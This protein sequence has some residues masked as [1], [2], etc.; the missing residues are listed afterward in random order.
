[1]IEL[2]VLGGLRLRDSADGHEI[3]SV[4]ARS[5]PPGVLLYLALSPADA[6]RGRDELLELLWP[7]SSAEKARNSLSQALHILRRGL[8]P[9]VIGTTEGD[10]L[11]LEAGTVWCDVAAFDEAIAS[12]HEREALELYGGHLWEGSDLS[13]YP[14][15]ERWLDQERQRLRLTAVE[16]AVTLARELERDGS[17]V[18]A[19]KWLRRARDWAPFDE[20][21]LQLLLKL[22]H[23][24][25]TQ[26]RKRSS[27]PRE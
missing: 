19:A 15:F 27:A 3:L 11:F 2:R 4:L 20:T 22:L 14:A 17:F 24:L 7:D 12:G 18:D 16:A 1:M 25:G 23:R 6:S 13:D 8:G 21:V 9:G 5:K 26:F 10:E